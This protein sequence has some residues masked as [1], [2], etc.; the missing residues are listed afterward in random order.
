LGTLFGI[1]GF[2]VFFAVIFAVSMILI[3]MVLRSGLAQDFAAAFQFEWIKDFISKMWL[4]ML[5]AGLFLV[6]TGFGLEIIGLAA[7]C[8]GL[9]FVLPLLLLAYAHILY[10]LYAVFLSRGGQPVLPKLPL[11]MMPQPGYVPPK[12]L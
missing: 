10:Q 9:F 2:L 1:T 6:A 8:V 4:E 12:Q 3:A 11:P 7:L 5:L